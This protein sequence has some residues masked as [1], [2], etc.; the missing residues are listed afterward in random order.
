M[1]NG[2][3]ISTKWFLVY[4]IPSQI[5]F[6]NIG[7][8]GEGKSPRE[9]GGGQLGIFWVGMCRPGLQIGTLF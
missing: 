4:L 7:F 1:I 5:G 8:W 9:G 3:S 6:W 2:R